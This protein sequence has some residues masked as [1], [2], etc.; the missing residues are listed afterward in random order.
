MG[1]EVQTNP[2]AVRG[3]ASEE[4]DVTGVTAAF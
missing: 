2:L 3:D 4:C 1:W